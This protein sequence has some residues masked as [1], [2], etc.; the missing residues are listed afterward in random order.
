MWGG[1]LS[2]GGLLSRLPGRTGASGMEE[3][4]G[5]AISMSERQRY[6]LI[7]RLLDRGFIL[8]DDKKWPSGGPC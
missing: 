8:A 5:H 2:C 3:S 6:A 7:M 1:L 4:D